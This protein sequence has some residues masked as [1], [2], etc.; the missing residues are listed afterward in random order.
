[1]AQ[2]PFQTLNTARRAV[3]LASALS[4]FG[5][6]EFVR[7]TGLAGFLPKGMMPVNSRVKGQPIPARVRMLL[8]ELGPTFIKAGQILSTRPDLIGPEW[9][10]E[11]KKLQASVPPAS[12][13][14]DDGIER[15]LAEAYGDGFKAVFAD[16]DEKPLAA[17]SMGQ[18]HA[19]TLV[20]GEKVVVKVLRPGIHERVVADMQLMRW[21]AGLVRSEFESHGLDIDDIVKEFAKQLERETDLTIE[22]R[23]TQRMASDFADHEGVSFA[24]VFDD[25]T[26]RN[27][28]V[29]ERVQG[30]VLSDVDFSSLSD[31]ARRKIVQH[32]ADAVFKQCLVFGFF[33]A[34]PHPGN[35]FLQD[36]DKLV[37]IDCGMAGVIDPGT[38]SLLAHIVYGAVKGDLN[39]V[40][41]SAI[42]LS[43]AEPGMMDDRTLRTDVWAFLDQFRGGSL[44]SI[45]MGAMLNEFMSLL[46]RHKLKCP[47]DIV[48]LIKAIT[49]IEGVAS[50]IDPTFDLVGYVQPYIEGLIKQRYTIDAVKQRMLDAA[51]AYSDLLE[52]MPVQISDLL[53]SARRNEL[54]LRLDHVGVE[55]LESTIRQSSMNVAW[56]LI[57]ASVVMAS[58]VLILADSMRGA[59]TFLSVLALAGFI[60]SG[61][62]GL[63]RLIRLWRR[64]G[65]AGV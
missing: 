11:L 42:R 12:W 1:M 63:V 9:I 41:R 30:T 55:E 61:G 14:G 39:S 6:G 48:Y 17:A 46:R 10:E 59:F 8:E 49:T 45:D 51:I 35:M 38:T 15:V 44:G 52:E 58:S 40:L 7:H 37:F 13:E 21:F 47:A 5:F 50:E 26:H 65:G 32:G 54:T 29:Q 28:M 64:H 4:S 36:G 56:S 53:H 3:E 31:E 57:L 33:H 62:I 20:T 60:V 34:D 2:S 18:V 25:L 16:F 24:K 27:V 22:A 19:A 23:S 43:G